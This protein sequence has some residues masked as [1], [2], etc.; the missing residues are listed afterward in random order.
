MEKLVSKASPPVPWPGRGAGVP[1]TDVRASVT[2]R[3]VDSEPEGGGEGRAGEGRVTAPT[4]HVVAC[5]E[6][7]HPGG[8]QTIQITSS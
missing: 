8:N 1:S 6:K 4:V 3:G 7:A 2:T 5:P